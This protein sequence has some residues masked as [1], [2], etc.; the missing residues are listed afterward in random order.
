MDQNPVMQGSGGST[1]NQNNQPANTNANPSAASAGNLSNG[2]IPDQTVNNPTMATGADGSAVAPAAPPKKKRKGLIATIIIILVLI[3]GLGGAV[4]WYFLYYNNPEKVAFDAINGFLQQKTV[5]TDGTFTGRAK[6]DSGEVLITVGLNNKSTTTSG[7]SIVTIKASMLDANGELLSDNQYE[8]ELGGIVLS[9]GVFY[10][11]TGKLMDTIDLLM[12]DMSIT[13][14]DLDASGQAIYRLLSNV[15]GEWWQFDVADVVDNVIEDPVL[16]RSTKE[17]YTCLVNVAHSD[18]NGELA[19]VYSQ[20]RFVNITPSSNKA[21][22]SGVTNYSVS[23]D[24]DKMAGFSN[25]LMESEIA[26]SAENCIHKYIVDD[27]G[28][29]VNF[30]NTP[31]E[32]DK[33]REGLEGTEFTLGIRDFGHELVSAGVSYK[34][35][36]AEFAGDFE[37]SH[38]E[39]IIEAPENYRPISDLVDMLV[40]A[41]TEMLGN[42]DEY[43][44]MDFIY[45][46]ETG[47]W[48]MIEDD[49]N[50]DGNYE[51]I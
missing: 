39:V 6:T 2:N 43:D 5:V 19:S 1:P 16:A 26:K 21:K 48:I 22:A 10:F 31:A 14:D 28:G 15:D 27:L 41:I 33:I 40:E 34:Q 46:E 3:L 4:A 44:D 47:E 13:I 50:E 17:F 37:F 20:N 32:A 42:T 35:D 51:E 11:R 23:I 12:D 29:E 18:I 8:V 7:N 25:A 38:P 30:E 9:D 36:D 49:I 45:D 24:Y